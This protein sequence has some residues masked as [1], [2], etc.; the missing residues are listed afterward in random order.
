MDI[1]AVYPSVK[2]GSPLEHVIAGEVVEGVM[3]DEE[4]GGVT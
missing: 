4:A 3:G 1:Q 2:Y